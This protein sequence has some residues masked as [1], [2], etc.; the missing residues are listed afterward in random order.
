MTLMFSFL[1]ATSSLHAATRLGIGAGFA[2]GVWLLLLAVLA[3]ATRPRNADAGP[4]TMELGGEETPAVVNL[5]LN[6]KV[7]PTA[8]PATLLDLAARGYVDIEGAGPERYVVRLRSRQ[9]PGESL[10]GYEKMLM[11]HLKTRA[12]DGIVPSG[13]LTTGPQAE[14]TSWWRRFRKA[15]VQEA[16]ERGLARPRWS[17]GVMVLLGLVAAVP[18][19]LGA[20]AIV[21]SDSNGSASDD[22]SVGA[23]IGLAVLIWVGLMAFVSWLRSERETKMGLAAQ[24]RWL[25]LWEYLRQNSRFGEAPPSA[26]A[27]WDRHLAYG[28]AMGVAGAA[29]RALPLGT[30]S[31]RRA[32][33][34]ATGRWREVRIRYPNPFWTGW[35]QKPRTALLGTI[36]LVAF[37]AVFGFS[38]VRP[39]FRIFRDLTRDGLDL[40]FGLPIGIALIV[41]IAM[42]FSL[43]IRTLAICVRAVLDA[44]KRKIVEGEVLR[45]WNNYV[46]IDD[47]RNTELKAWLLPVERSKPSRGSTVRITASPYLG[48][49]YAIDVVESAAQPEGRV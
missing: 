1:L 2:L 39:L 36:P 11:D 4:A 16:K 5:L 20:I 40:V 6:W 33:S 35:G 49:V 24:S 48:Y 13:A 21:I 15:V 25:G 34:H 43:F 9:D 30:E 47:G 46:A 3:T 7:T 14:S 37:G 8:L 22:D 28:A 44:G 18:A 45:V 41:V 26:V 32:W 10:V 29:V 17:A 19:I 27:I 12:R 42:A 31:H 38:I 23:I